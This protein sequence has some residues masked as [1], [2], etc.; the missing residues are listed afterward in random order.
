MSEWGFVHKKKP[1]SASKATSL[2][3]DRLASRGACSGMPLYLR[4]AGVDEALRSPGQPLDAATRASMEPG[5]GHD[6]SQVRVH[7]GARS[8]QSADAINALAYTV[9]PEIVFAAGRYAPGTPEG[10]QLLAHELA[11]TVQ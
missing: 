7:T 4:K 5:F 8:A 11:H 9:G 2:E 3:L 6:F 1:T 10:R